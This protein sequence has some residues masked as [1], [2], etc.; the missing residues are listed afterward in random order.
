VRDTT[1]PLSVALGFEVENAVAD[2]PRESLLRVPTLINHFGLFGSLLG[3]GTGL[4]ERKYPLQT[5]ITCGVSETVRLDLTAG[6]L[7]PAVLPE[8]RRGHESHRL[9][10]AQ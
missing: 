1:V 3:N 7:R 4:D 9:H 8:L 5:Q 2:G 10:C 6:S